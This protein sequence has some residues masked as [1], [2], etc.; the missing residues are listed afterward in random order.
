MLLDRKND[1]DYKVREEDLQ[2]Y[3]P[4]P[5]ESKKEKG[6]VQSDHNPELPMDMRQ[7][8]WQNTGT[9]IPASGQTSPAEL[10]PFNRCLHLLCNYLVCKNHYNASHKTSEIIIVTIQFFLYLF[11]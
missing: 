7:F 4:I 3:L 9:E 8:V 1:V 2:S 6:M 5:N 11:T 10:L